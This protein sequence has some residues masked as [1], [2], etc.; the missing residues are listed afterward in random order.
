M[1]IL[2]IRTFP[3]PVLR[4]TC[5]EAVPGTDETRE[6]VM[7]MLET[8]YAAPGIG[9]AAPQVGEDVRLI[10]V[11]ITGHLGEP[12]PH[13]LLNPKLVEGEG[14]MTFEEGCLSVPEFLIEV[15][16]SQTVT[17]SYQDVE[18]ESC[19]VTAE[20]L[21]A[22]AIQHEMDHLEGRLILDYASAIRRD[23]YRRKIR[24]MNAGEGA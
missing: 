15:D 17:V 2:T 19:Q 11:D 7:N 22:I 14:S 3:D 20:D 9:L 13:V 24:K 5:V 18:G 23:Q 16:R 10:I 12:E 8:M 4:K 1:P 6:L 21:L